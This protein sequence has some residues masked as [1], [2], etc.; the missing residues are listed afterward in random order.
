MAIPA[1]NVPSVAT[2]ISVLKQEILKASL[3]LPKIQEASLSLEETVRNSRFVEEST[4]HEAFALKQSAHNFEHNLKFAI[5]DIQER[6]ASL[7]LILSRNAIIP[8]TLTTVDDISV[9]FYIAVNGPV[10]DWPVAEM[11]LERCSFLFI[12]ELATVANIIEDTFFAK[13]IWSAVCFESSM[14][15]LL[16]EGDCWKLRKLISLISTMVKTDCDL[17]VSTK[18]LNSLASVLLQPL[19]SSP[20]DEEMKWVY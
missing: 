2:A 12:E 14:V 13:A 9:A 20:E 15:R 11:V 1:I 3:L 4:H 17:K 18:I 10:I 5:A 7:E 8:T 16:E 19:R 6:L